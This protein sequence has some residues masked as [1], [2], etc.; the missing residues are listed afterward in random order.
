MS[1]ND[2]YTPKQIEV[3]KTVRNR[4]WH[5]LI[6]HGAV[7]TGKTVLD[8]D[9][10]LMALMRV[11]K[12]ADEEG[13]REP[14]YILAGVSSKTITNNVLSE[15]RNRYGLNFKFDRQGDFTL[16][17]VKVVLAY[18]G[19]I[20]GLGRIR[21]MTAYGAYVNEASLAVKE[22]FAEI[23]NRCSKPN[24]QI[25]CDTNPD[26]PEH[27]LKKDYIDKAGTEKGKDILEF[28]FELDDNT[29]L[30]DDYREH[31]KNDT[32]SGMLYDRNING[33]WVA[34]EGMVY[35]DFD[36]KTMSISEQ[37]MKELHFDRIVCGVDWGWEHWGSIVIVGINDGQDVEHSNYYVIREYAHQHYDINDWVSVAKDIVSEFGNVPFYCDSARPEHVARF[38][39]EGLNA[40]NAN[41]S[42]MPGIETVAKTMKQGRFKI[43]YEHAPRF[44]EEIFTYVWNEQTGMPNKQMD[45]TQDAIRY[46]IYSD[47]Q[48]Q[49]QRNQSNINDRLS[50]LKNLGF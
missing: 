6:N 12:L 14:K 48:V 5:I 9:L 26:S 16:F 35:P 20:S 3:L 13:E 42:I 19:S 27:W 43:D 44:R 36:R 33:L 45:D 2:L 29:F 46:A 11:R 50:A 24:A 40:I 17:G 25:I 21:G 18:T 39:N 30:P 49:E 41:K 37:E 23:V 32:P 31:I 7:R 47:L 4:P 15:L 1:L 28:K 22:V 10:F 38:V 8:N 34:G